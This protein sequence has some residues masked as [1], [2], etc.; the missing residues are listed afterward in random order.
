MPNIGR[1]EVEQGSIARTSYAFSSEPSERLLRALAEQLKVPL[2]QIAR[3]AELGQLTDTRASLKHI[4]YTADMALGLVDS[5]LLSVQLQALPSLELEP[6]SLSAM[7]Q[8]TVHKLHGMAQ[9]YNCEVELHLG[10]KYEP[11]MAHRQSLESAYMALGYAFIESVPAVDVSSRVLFA[12]HRTRQGLVAGV[13]GEQPGL[14]VDMYRRARALYG[15]ARQALPAMSASSSAGVFVADSLLQNMATPLR[16]ARHQRLAGL[17]A[18][19]FPSKQLQ[20]V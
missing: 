10:G 15:H 11:V 2:L 5:Y 17:A 18:T 20:L 8:D 12:A 19:L 1:L 13:F 6:I 4:E 14:S 9:Q 16:V 3:E 7:L